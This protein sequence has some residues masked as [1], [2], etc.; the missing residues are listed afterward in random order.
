VDI[1]ETFLEK[2]LKKW[3][4]MLQ[5][6]TGE[7]FGRDRFLRKGSNAFPLEKPESMIS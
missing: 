5:P 7:I 6:G 1:L 3:Y 4:I 2:H